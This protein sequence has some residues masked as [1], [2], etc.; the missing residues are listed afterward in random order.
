MRVKQQA[1]AAKRWLM[2]TRRTRR[3]PWHSLQPD[4]LLLLLPARPGR[5]ADTKS[6]FEDQH[7]DDEEVEGV[8]SEALATLPPAAALK[9]PAA[10]S[11]PSSAFAD[12]NSFEGAAARRGR[13]GAGRGGRPGAPTPRTLNNLSARCASSP[14]A[15]MLP[16]SFAQ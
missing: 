9:P 5:T 1:A 7:C 11:S 2:S 12:Q 3:K 14:P 4:T 15:L 8:L 13:A 16:D 6:D 10:P